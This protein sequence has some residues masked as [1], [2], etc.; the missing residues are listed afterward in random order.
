MEVR[1][2]CR[3]KSLHLPEL[4]RD[5]KKDIIA[6]FTSKEYQKSPTLREAID[7]DW[8]VVL[9]KA[10]TNQKPKLTVI[11]KP[12]VVVEIKSEKQAIS[13]EVVEDKV[14]EQ[15]KPKRGR[16]KKDEKNS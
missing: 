1:V 3:V 14:E 11:E 5:L 16:H 7:N 8:V 2:K 6:D 10:S 13:K 9:K 4:S 15:K 12:K